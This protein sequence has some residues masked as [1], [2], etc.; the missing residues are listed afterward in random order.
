MEMSIDSFI[1][2]VVIIIIIIIILTKLLFW[3]GNSDMVA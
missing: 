1:V 3:L 2:V